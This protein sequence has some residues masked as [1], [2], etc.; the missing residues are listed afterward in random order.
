VSLDPS[1]VME[2]LRA[3]YLSRE[4]ELRAR[5][6][7]SL[8]FQDAMFD[9][10]ERA[11][12]LG[13]G[14]GASI[15]NSAAVF[16]D[17]TVGPASWIGPNVVLDGSAAPV[18]IGRYCSISAGAMVF[19]HDT[20]LWAVSGGRQRGRTGPVTIA[21]N[22]YVGSQCVIVPGVTIG[23]RVVVAANS[24]VNR[25]VAEGTIV[26]GTPAREIGRV[27]VGDDGACSLVYHGRDG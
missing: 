3:A 7:R 26:A 24:L 27:V 14:E 11:R 23:S 15:Y 22:V 1:A 2:A 20:V 25:P 6:A 19:T 18:A 12:R 10:W 16:G 21:D 17:V 9:R 5:F 8:P 4:E 13:F